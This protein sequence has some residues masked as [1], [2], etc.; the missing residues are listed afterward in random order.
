MYV[1]VPVWVL[2]G[3]CCPDWLVVILP[4]EVVSVGLSSQPDPFFSFWK[5]VEDEMIQTS[6]QV[7]S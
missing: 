1:I 4:L 7:R 3:G 6:S 5:R 2:S